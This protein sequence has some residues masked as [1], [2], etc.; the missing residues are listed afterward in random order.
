MSIAPSGITSFGPVNGVTAV[1]FGYN[2]TR[3]A[4]GQVMYLGCTDSASPDMVVTNSGSFEVARFGAFGAFSIIGTGT[5][6][7]WVATSDLNLKDV[8]G[9]VEPRDFSS[10]AIID[11]DWKDGSGYGIGVGAQHVEAIAPEYVT[12]KDGV[13]AVDKSGL[14][15][16]WCAS[17]ERKLAALGVSP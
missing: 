13:R 5:G 17:I 8:R 2:P 14:A 7:N 3:S 15:L 12:E 9:E 4:A 10:L 1:G 11:W 6:V 16:E